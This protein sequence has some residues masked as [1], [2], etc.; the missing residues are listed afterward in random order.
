MQQ[1]RRGLP[2]TAAAQ[3]RPGDE[4]TDVV[5]LSVQLLQQQGGATQVPVV[6]LGPAGEQLAAG[7]RRIQPGH[8]R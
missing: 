6:P 1:V 3:A 8:D 7:N 5:A 4:T 2:A